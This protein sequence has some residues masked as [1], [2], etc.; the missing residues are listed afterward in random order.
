[1]TSDQAMAGLVSLVGGGGLSAVM[2]AVMGFLTEARKGRKPGDGTVAISI[3]EKLA[4]G[5]WD[6][7]ATAHLATIAS[8]MIRLVAVKEIEAEEA[9]D[10][11]DFA[12]R[13]DMK[14]LRILRE[15][16]R[17]KEQQSER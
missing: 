3:G 12:D 17:S 7:E 16:W 14:E 1:M 6:E 13:L 10:G 9:F 4:Q 5:K 2:V 8:V 15:A 11:K